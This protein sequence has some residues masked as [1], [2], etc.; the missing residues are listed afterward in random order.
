MP[1]SPG[2]KH[3][4]VYSRLIYPVLA[5]I[6]EDREGLLLGGCGVVLSGH[7][8][9]VPDL[10][11]V[12]HERMHLLGEKYI[13]GAPDM[14]GEIISPASQMID[15]V[16]KRALYAKHGVRYYWL[17]HPHEEWL[18]VYELSADGQYELVAEGHGD[19]TLSAPPFPDLPIQLAQLW[20]DPFTWGDD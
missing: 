5:Q 4:R 15:T 17:I 11:F 6:R 7:T 2:P 14:L 10:L 20:K 3:Q 13:E 19:M 9:I 18:R 16:D 12:S 1:R 8:L